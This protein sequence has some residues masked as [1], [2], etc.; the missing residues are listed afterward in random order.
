MLDPGAAAVRVR[1]LEIAMVLA[2]EM[3]AAAARSVDASLRVEQLQEVLNAP[4]LD[5]GERTRIQTAL[6]MAGLEPRPSLLEAGPG[7]S[8][9]FGLSDPQPA[10]SEPADAAEA[11]A[12]GKFARS[13]LERARRRFGST[14]AETANGNGHHAEPAM[15]TA[16]DEHLA[17]DPDHPAGPEFGGPVPPEDLADAVD[18]EGRKR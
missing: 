6:Q 15:A 12:P 8:V 14:A 1:D 16:T 3:K 18:G 17:T 10:A 4:E 5:Q 13:T 7:D 9:R 11:E 2:R